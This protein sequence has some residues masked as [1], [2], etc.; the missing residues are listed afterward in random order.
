[1]LADKFVQEGRIYHNACFKCK[2]CSIKL[3]DVNPSHKEGIPYCKNHYLELFGKSKKKEESS[4]SL[5]Q[6]EPKDST[7]SVQDQS[8][9][10]R[11][12]KKRKKK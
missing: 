10:N 11:R 2:V 6:E 4:D 9:K 8:K 5:Q 1:V 3:T 7:P 12:S